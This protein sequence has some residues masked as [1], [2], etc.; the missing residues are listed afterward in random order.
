MSTL[1]LGY[2][3]DS[4]AAQ[5]AA[6]LDEGIKQ[7]DF[8]APVTIVVPNRYLGK[9]LRLW[10]AR[11]LG[12]AINLRFKYL[13]IAMWDMLRELDSR[14]HAFPVK[15]LDNQDFRLMILSVLLREPA[16]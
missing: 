13:E 4:L 15:M 9:W 3:Q 14:Q 11:H 2:D 10:L 8:F 1:Y 16:D 6:G 12:I 7:G 5:L